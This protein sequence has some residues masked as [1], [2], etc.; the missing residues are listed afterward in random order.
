MEILSW[1]GAFI[2]ILSYLLLSINKLSSK[3]VIYHFMN[4]IGSII[5]ILFSISKNANASIFINSIFALI[6]LITIIKLK[7]DE[8]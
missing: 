6:A 2:L 5:F 7:K 3:S 8:N 1:I 4:L